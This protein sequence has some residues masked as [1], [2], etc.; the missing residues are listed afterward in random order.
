MGFCTYKHIF[1]EPNKGVHSTRIFGL[2]AV[3]V[4]MTIAAAVAI[5]TMTKTSFIV[6]FVA[7]MVLAILCHRL[8]CV[9][10]VLNRAIFGR[11]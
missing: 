9:D 3:D 5:K 11:I 2:A 6:A 8:F 4:G 10:T 7:L 1:G